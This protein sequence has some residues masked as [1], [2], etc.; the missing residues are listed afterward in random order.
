[1]QMRRMIS[2]DVY[3]GLM[4]VTRDSYEDAWASLISTLNRPMKRS[5]YK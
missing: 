4:L 5:E 2:G 1:M 3:H